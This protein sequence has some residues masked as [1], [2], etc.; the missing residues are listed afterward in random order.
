[1]GEPTPGAEAEAAV[2]ATTRAL[3]GT[4][5]VVDQLENEPDDL[6]L[7]HVAE[8]HNGGVSDQTDL[9]LYSASVFLLKDRGYE[10]GTEDGRLVMFDPQGSVVDLNSFEFDG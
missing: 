7:R 6:L 8:N 10:T 2:D 9:T 1:M 3:E 5:S 4:A